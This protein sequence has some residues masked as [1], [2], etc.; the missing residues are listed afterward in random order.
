MAYVPRIEVPEGYYHVGTRGNN[1]RA[2]FLDEHDRGTFLI[3]L[4]RVAAKYRWTLYAYCLMG[5]HYHLVLQLGDV[6]LSDGMCELNT[7]YATVFN[8]RHGREN[9][10]FGRRFWDERI[11]TDRQLLESC[12]YVVLNPCRA[13]MCRTPA[14]WAWSSYRATI[15]Q[16]LVFPGLATGLLLERFSRDPETAVREYEVYCAERPGGHVRR[17]P[18]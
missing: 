11:K 17:Q 16:A 15:G 1:K 9:H 14:D 12:R 5:N 13:G 6:G 18:P 2:I 10:L 3:I 4:R 8:A 7:A